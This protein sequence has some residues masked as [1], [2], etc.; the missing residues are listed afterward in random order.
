MIP[1]T[2]DNYLKALNEIDNQ[3]IA[4]ADRIAD[5]QKS[6]TITKSDKM[7]RIALLEGSIENLEQQQ[8]EIN[9]TYNPDFKEK[10][11]YRRHTHKG[12][13]PFQ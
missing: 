9:K 3:I 10:K 6:K 11:H 4:L 2:A 12:M 7:K 1:I 5:I 8:F 13:S